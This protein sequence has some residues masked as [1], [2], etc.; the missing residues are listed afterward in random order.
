MESLSLLAALTIVSGALSLLCLLILH[1]VSPEFHPGWRMISEY[2]LGKHKRILTF[3]FTFWCISSVLLACLLWQIVTTKWALFGAV[4]VFVSGIGALMGGLFDVKHKLHGFAS[5]LGVPTLPAGALL[6]SYNLVQQPDWMVHKASILSS[7]HIL[8]VSVVL[9][10]V[11]MMLLFSGFKKAGYSMG[12]NVEPP[13]TLPAGVIGLNGYAN[14]FLVLCYIGWLVL[15]AM[16][17][18]SFQ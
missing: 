11:T 12:P 1:F 7:A 10:I 17:Y 13:E 18:L 2:A 14:R 16:I 6:V 9:M 15:I 4:L 5:T 8:W 3:F